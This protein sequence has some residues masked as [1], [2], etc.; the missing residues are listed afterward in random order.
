MENKDLAGW[1]Q[2]GGK[3][4]RVVESE[5]PYI[6]GFHVKL[7]FVS[8]FLLGQI[9]DISREYWQNPRTGLREEN[10]NE[11]KLREAYADFVISDW[12][13]LTI[14]K[15][16]KLVPALEVKGDVTEETDVPFSR[17]V[18]LALLEQSLEFEN[19]VV[20]I[21]TDIRNYSKIAELKEK[22]YQNLKK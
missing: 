5:C 12:K 18:V 6:P 1:I 8:K 3:T 19:W 9:R 20:S 10:F 14:G 21:A 17:D 15:L 2:K 7:T 16:R 4:Q 11:Q 13:G 22:E